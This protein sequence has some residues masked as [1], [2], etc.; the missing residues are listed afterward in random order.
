MRVTFWF[1]VGV[2]R[3]LT[4]LGIK[5]WE[6]LWASLRDRMGIFAERSEMVNRDAEMIDRPIW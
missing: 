1:G 2:R 4:S 5:V 3:V 6:T